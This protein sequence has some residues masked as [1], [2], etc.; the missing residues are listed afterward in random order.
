MESAIPNV[1]AGLR[2][3]DLLPLSPQVGA[4]VPTGVSSPAFIF[5][6]G[7][8]LRAAIFSLALQG[9]GPG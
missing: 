4:G 7:G 1:G 9:R 5:N 3:G 2:T 6:V 8:A